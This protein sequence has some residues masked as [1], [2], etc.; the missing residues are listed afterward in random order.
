M[1][2]TVC[3]RVL[4]LAAADPDRACFQVQAGLLDGSL[5]AFLPVS[6]GAFARQIA[7]VGRRLRQAGVEE[8]DRVLW[9]LPNSVAWV[10]LDLACQDLGAVSVVVHPGTPDAVRDRI[11]AQASPRVV[12]VDGS[13]TWQPRCPNVLHLPEIER[14]P[15]ER[16]GARLRPSAI[17]PGNLATVMYTS[18]STGEPK[19]AELTHEGLYANA[20]ATAEALGLAPDDVVP[21]VLSFSHS[22]GRTALLHSALCAGCSIAV[23]DWIDLEADPQLVAAAGPTTLVVV[24]RVLDRLL[25]GWREPA[26]LQRGDPF[27]R[28]RR[29]LVGGASLPAGAIQELEARGVKVFEAYGATEATCTVTMQRPG[30]ERRGTVGRPLP[31]VEVR[32]ADDGEILCRGANVMR[33]FH[34]DAAATAEALD[35]DGWLRTGDLGSVDED[36]FLRLVGRKK[37]VFLASDGNHF[38]PARIEAMLEAVPVIAEAVLCGDGRPFVGAFVVPRFDRLRCPDLEPHASCPRRPVCPR[39]ARDMADC[40]RMERHL[41]VEVEGR[42][43]A[44]LPPC[45]R[46]Q[47]IRVLPEG[48]P[49][50]IRAATATAKLRVQRGRFLEAFGPQIERLYGSVPSDL[51]VARA[52]FAR[53]LRGLLEPVL[54]FHESWT[55]ADPDGPGGA[56]PIPAG[57]AFPE[58]PEHPEAILDRFAERVGR[59]S[60]RFAAPNYA[61]HMTSSL[62]GIGIAGAAFM[63]VL[64]QNQVSIDASPATTALELETVRWLA[65]LVGYDPAQAAGIGAA[66][67]SIA[68]ITALLAARNRAL[69]GSA[70]HGVRPE[71]GGAIVVS[72][73]M[74]YSFRRAAELLGLGGDRGLVRIPVD[75]TNRID[76]DQLQRRLDRLDLARRKIVALVAIAGTSETGNVDPIAAMADIAAERGLWFHVDAAMGGAALAS[77]RH[78]ARFAGIERAHSVTVDP[79]KWFYVPYHCAYV[80]FRDRALLRE[81]ELSEPHFVVLRTGEADLGKWS[82]EGSR[83]ANAVKFWM[84]AQALGRRGYAALVDHQ[85]ELVAELATLVDRSRDLERLSVPELNILCFRFAPRDLRRALKRL[86]VRSVQAREINAWLDAVNVRLYSRLRTNGRAAL[87]RTTLEATKHGVPVV[88][89]RGVFFHPAIG[90]EDLMRLLEAVQEAGQEAMQEQG[91]YPCAVPAVDS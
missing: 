61:A 45:Q 83:A 49:A 28:L 55:G 16:K 90:Q 33:G 75:A 59:E 18:G 53:P 15:P 40:A 77:P 74:H 79:H 51:A 91:E 54:R 9:S 2:S 46:L 20:A 8:G 85:I 24:P 87:S 27:A 57:D 82:I 34:G 41:M 44:V 86:P 63:A 66:G 58:A 72:H 35:G 7:A 23:L 4:D 22:A 62:P 3:S 65:D 21:A 13:A 1:T 14:A 52:A 78:R 10:A 30:H 5:P 38:A 67:G 19:G 56:A 11:L 32:I 89:L 81:V 47:R 84:V 76:V 69:P 6:R 43:N 37:D 12:V 64:N 88:A 17:A 80:L 42:V 29:I 48:F 73:R 31:G 26:C 70:D 71:D 36:G 25:H 68:N 60:I 39:A 50:E